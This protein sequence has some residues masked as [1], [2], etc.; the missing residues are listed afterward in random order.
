MK[1]L[2]H[3]VSLLLLLSCVSAANTN[4]VDFNKYDIDSEVK[5]IL[6][7]GQNNEAIIVLTSKGTVYRSRDK[8][9]SWKKLQ[10]I[11]NK[12]GLQVADDNQEVC[13]HFSS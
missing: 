9:S 5:D 10:S 1:T 8:G 6:W 2:K 12:S 11:L 3:L 7:C 4:Q 13:R